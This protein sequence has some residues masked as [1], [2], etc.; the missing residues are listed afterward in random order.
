[1]RLDEVHLAIRPRTLLECLDLSI[2]VWGRH[3]P[4]LSIATIIGVAPMVATQLWLLEIYAEDSGI[5][6]ILLG[7]VGA[8]W[9]TMPILIYLGQITFSRRFSLRQAIR[10][11]MGA[12]PCF[13]VYQGIMRFFC[14]FVVV[15][16]PM[17]FIGM[18]YLSPIVLL[19]R[20]TFNRV[21]VRRT[22]MNSRNTGRIIS[23]LVTDVIVMYAGTYCLGNFLRGLFSLWTGHFEQGQF[24]GAGT[25][26]TESIE[27]EYLL[28][29]WLVMSFLA[30]FRFIT[31][32]DCRI[33]REGWDV[34]LKLRAEAAHF[35]NREVA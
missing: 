33:R 32:L 29:F 8:P 9:V 13:F 4:G 6:F 21:W 10:T 30:V 14:I 16:S 15:L 34:E 12:L 28:A 24:L 2:R 25:V 1:M 35:P 31:Y 5:P 11:A 23:F 20:P 19:E 27:W 26:T 3:F 7:M 22:A 17:I 18:Y